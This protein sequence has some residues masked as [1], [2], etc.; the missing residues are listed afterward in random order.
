MKK[1]YYM[2]KQTVSNFYLQIAVHVSENA[3]VELASCK[4]ICY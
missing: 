4:T 1:M 2:S 3:L